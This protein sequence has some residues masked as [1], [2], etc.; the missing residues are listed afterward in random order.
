[1]LSFGIALKSKLSR[2]LVAGNF[3]ALMRRSTIRLSRQRADVRKS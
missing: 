3:A 1:L 2:L